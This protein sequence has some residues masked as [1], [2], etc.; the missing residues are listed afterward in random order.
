MSLT[1]LEF[2]KSFLK[3]RL[4]P[5]IFAEAYI[6]LWKIER[7][8][9]LILQDPPLLSEVLSTIFCIS[10]NYYPDEDRL[11]SEFNSEQLYQHVQAELN[12]LDLFQKLI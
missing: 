6:E 9:N 10:D 8:L 5:K 12:R 4:E 1:L 3:N 7:D 11:E 2:T